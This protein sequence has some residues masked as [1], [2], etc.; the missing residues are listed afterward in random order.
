MHINIWNRLWNVNMQI[1]KWNLLSLAGSSQFCSS[2][3]DPWHSGASISL[4]CK[5]ARDLVLT[6]LFSSSSQLL[7]EVQYDHTKFIQV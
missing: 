3:V 7:H 5:H 6:Y 4:V 2:V 1:L